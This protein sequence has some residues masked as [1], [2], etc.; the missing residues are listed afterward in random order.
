MGRCKALLFRPLFPGAVAFAASNGV[1][2]FGALPPATT[3]HSVLPSPLPQEV[4]RLQGLVEEKEGNLAA[5][6]ASAGPGP[7]HGGSFKT[8][9]MN[10]LLFIVKTA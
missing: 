6:Q 1:L 4:A 5:V 7:N 8:S 10:T 3:L 9:L 2:F